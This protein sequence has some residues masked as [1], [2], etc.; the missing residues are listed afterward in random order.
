MGGSRWIE[1][2]NFKSKKAK[3][4]LSVKW[5]ENKVPKKIIEITV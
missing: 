2:K 5:G 3:K 4:K 1:G